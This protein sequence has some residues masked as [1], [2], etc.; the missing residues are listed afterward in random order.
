MRA[1]AQQ[2]A[3]Y[4]AA[5]QAPSYN[6]SVGG[7]AAPHVGG[8]AAGEQ[9]PTA[10]E[11]VDY[12]RYIGMDPIADVNL[13]WIAEEALCAALPEGW[14]EYTDAEGNPFYYHATTGVSTWE[15]PLDEYYRSLFMKLKKILIDNR[16][17]L[18]IND[19]AVLLQ[20]ALRCQQARRI[21]RRLLGRKRL[22]DAAAD[23]QAVYRGHLVRLKV[24]E[25]SIKQWEELE[26]FSSTRLQATYRAHL[27]RRSIAKKREEWKREWRRRAAAKLQATWRGHVGRRIARE[28]EMYQALELDEYAVTK[29]Q[30]VY[31][32]HVGRIRF[33][34]RK[35]QLAIDKILKSAAKIQAVYRGHLARLEANAERELQMAEIEFEAALRVQA[36]MRGHWGRQL[37]RFRRRN[38]LAS[39]IQSVYRGHIARLDVLV[40]QRYMAANKLQAV[41]R[42]H[43][44]RRFMVHHRQVVAIIR[45][46]EWEQACALKLQSV[47]RGHLGRVDGFRLIRQTRSALRLQATYRGHL[48]RARLRQSLAEEYAAVQIQRVWTGHTGRVVFRHVSV[49]VRNERAALRLQK[50]YR[51]HLARAGL[52]GFAEKQQAAREVQRVY[53][54]HLGRAGWRRAKKESEEGPMIGEG[55]EV[56]QTL[57][58]RH[59]ALSIQR[60]YRGH[61][62]RVVVQTTLEA[63]IK[64]MQET[65]VKSAVE[66]EAAVRIQ[67]L[68]RGTAARKRVAALREEERLQALGE[69]QDAATAAAP[70]ATE[71]AAADAE[72]AGEEQA[73]E[74]AAKP[75]EEQVEGAVAA[76]AEAEAGEEG[77]KAEEEPPGEEP[78][79][80]VAGVDG[81]VSRSESVRSMGSQRS[82]RSSSSV[83]S[84][85][86]TRAHDMRSQKVAQDIAS[87]DGKP[88]LSR[89]GSTRGSARRI[90]TQDQSDP[91]RQSLQGVVDEVM[92][93]ITERVIHVL[94]MPRRS[95]AGSAASSI[96][97]EQGREELR[98][99]N[100]AVSSLMGDIVSSVVNTFLTR[101]NTATSMSSQISGG[102]VRVSSAPAPSSASGFGAA[103]RMPG[104]A[105]PGEFGPPAGSDGSQVTTPG[106]TPRE[107][108]I[109]P[110]TPARDASALASQPEEALGYVP[111]PGQPPLEGLAEPDSAPPTP[112]PDEPPAQEESEVQTPAQSAPPTPATGAVAPQ[113]SLISEPGEDGQPDVLP[114]GTPAYSERPATEA[115]SF[116]TAV[117]AFEGEPTPREQ[118]PQTATDR[119]GTEPEPA[120]EKPGSAGQEAVGTEQEQAPETPAEVPG[121]PL[122]IPPA[123]TTTPAQPQVDPEAEARAAAEAAAAEAKA[124]AEAEE[125]ERRRQEE[126]RRKAEEVARLQQEVD[127]MRQE[128]AGLYEEDLLTF[129]DLYMALDEPVALS[130]STSGLEE[131]VAT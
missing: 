117:S 22:D 40:L 87:R 54:G 34:A 69:E 131:P 92:S 25:Q 102:G 97:T 78:A 126:E 84:H 83:G 127:A 27:V 43:V 91:G 64:D 119:P 112:P 61:L 23:I 109:P 130:D 48:E 125:E 24:R 1:P 56:S 44:S 122:P 95:G 72:Q 47:Y 6:P 76:T 129:F 74:E 36:C 2:A 20:C 79:A 63:M 111:P 115:G 99:I 90:D 94:S 105:E 77:A 15:H 100:S 5:A 7:G 89:K 107:T 49:V 17:A 8:A 38:F 58:A 108:P 114:P 88:P 65:D 67:S 50:T 66:E 3:I 46:H 30:S 59:A 101:P 33:R 81:R 41:Y 53:R 51:G 62:D 29:L 31:R 35:K 82:A 39:K 124:K 10:Q 28:E 42:G 19:S 26:K 13:L 120:E 116:V 86:S 98:E 71:A 4:Q 110:S 21:F 16:A 12:A 45:L 37:T 32:G 128:L 60:V 85:K 106:L 80:G 123:P 55:V 118:T 104:Q 52:V 14:G 113:P 9:G 121:T 68:A 18:K 96:P 103:S 75:E 70:A 93:S 73:G 57:A 11:I